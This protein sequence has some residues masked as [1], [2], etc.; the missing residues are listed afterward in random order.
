VCVCVQI[1]GIPARS[2]DDVLRLLGKAATGASRITL[3]L[4]RRD[5]IPQVGVGS[6]N[7]LSRLL[8][9]MRYDVR[10]DSTLPKMSD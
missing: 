4:A 2:R 1:N 3:T 6:R 10:A 8:A 9:T 5:V 7:D